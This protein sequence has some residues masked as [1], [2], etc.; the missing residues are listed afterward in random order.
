MTDNSIAK[1]NKQLVNEN[2]ILRFEALLPATCGTCQQEYC[3]KRDDPVPSLACHGCGQGFHQECLETLLGEQR[4]SQIFHIGY[5]H[6]VLLPIV[7]LL[8]L[9]VDWKDQSLGGNG[10]HLLRA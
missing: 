7:L 2:I 6:C 9:L 8:Q 10:F 1:M 4:S 3:V 5:V